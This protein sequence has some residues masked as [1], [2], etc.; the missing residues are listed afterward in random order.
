MTGINLKNWATPTRK[1]VI[2]NFFK[3]GVILINQILLVPIYLKFWGV[4]LYGDWIV[5]SAITSFFTMSDAGLNN[6]T[7][8]RF[9]IKFSQGELD[10]CSSLIVNNYI[11]VFLTAISVTLLTI[12]V[13][14][15]FDIRTILSLNVISSFEASAVIILLLLQVFIQ[16]V[17]TISNSIYHAKGLASRATYFDNIARLFS[18][19]G[20]L[21]G[22]YCHFSLVM[23]VVL[24]SLPYLF[25]LVYKYFN[26]K[27]LYDVGLTLQKADMALFKKVI[28]PSMSYLTF[29]IGN[30]FIFQVFSLILNKFLGP[31]L[32]VQFNTTRTMANFIRSIVQSIAHAVKPEFSMLY[33]LK[34]F[35]RLKLLLRKTILICLTC[36]ILS[37][38]AVLFFGD[39]IYQKWTYGKIPFDF[40]LVLLFCLTIV[41]NSIWESSIIAL[42][43]TNNHTKVGLAYLFSCII[44]S[45][46]AYLG[47]LQWNN[48][49]IIASCLIISDLI[50][51]FFSVRESRK[52]IKNNN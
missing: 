12:I 50:M 5:L 2:A 37:S 40:V 1:N 31:T 47:A 3:I 8:N 48:L 9:C 24:S 7:I 17:S 36:S 33:G 20:I 29:P 14:I 21:A 41:I 11:F 27:I 49:Y 16:M 34:N 15:L 25:S 46:M 52:L 38:V 4:E 26:S 39:Y 6:V 35:V 23:V 51:A 28:R 22:I 45:T 19:F 10:E 18:G 32:L 42:T 44:A 13:L 30:V 43:S